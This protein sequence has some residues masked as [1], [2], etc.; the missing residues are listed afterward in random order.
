[1]EVRIFTTKLIVCG[2]R[3][4][5]GSEAI[6]R[7]LSKYCPRTTTIV[8]GAARGADT[9][10]DEV[11]AELGMVRIYYMAK[12][13][14]YGRAAGPIRNQQM[15]DEEKPDK[16][17]AFHAN[18]DQSKGTKHMVKIAQEAGIPVEIFKS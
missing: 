10:A 16:V 7:E 3:N 12:W 6:Y 9:I 8:H 14:E 13:A 11:A 17:L 1:M 18:L 2:D 4:W 5:V 15:L